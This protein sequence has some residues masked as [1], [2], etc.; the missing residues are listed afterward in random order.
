[1]RAA[2]ATL[3]AAGALTAWQYRDRLSELFRGHAGN[4]PVKKA[5]ILI[6]E[7]DSPAG[8]PDIAVATRDLVAAALD[9]S[10]IVAPVPRGELRVALQMAGRADT[11]RVDAALAQ[12]LAYRSAIRTVVEGRVGRL[13]DGYT[14]VVRLVDAERDSVVLSLSEVASNARALIPAVERA[15]RRIREGL[16]EHRSDIQASRQLF[17]AMTPSFEAYRHYQS[18]VTQVMG[19]DNLGGLAS[20]RAALSLDPDFASTLRLM[21]AAFSNIGEVDSALAA[22]RNALSHPRRLSS[23]QRLLCEAQLA[24]AQG[25]VS[26]A[27]ANYERL[28]EQ[29]PTYMVG[30]IVR[31]YFLY[32]AGRYEEAL[33]SLRVAAEASPFGPSQI[34]LLN[35]FITYLAVGRMEEARQV[36]GNLKGEFGQS[37]P[38]WIGAASGNWALTES[39]G[40][41]LKASPTSSPEMRRLGALAVAAGAASRG[42]VGSAERALRR[43]EGW[44][45]A[46]STPAARVSRQAGQRARLLLALVSGGVAGAPVGGGIQETTTSALVTRGL[47]AAAA[48]DTTHARRLLTAARSRPPGEF[49]REGAGPALL[50][51]LIAAR[52]GFWDETV[53]ILEPA[54]RQGSEIGLFE[55]AGGRV[56]LRWV[57]A[58]AYER[59]GRPDS[60]AAYLEMLG[61]PALVWVKVRA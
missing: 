56:T 43:A 38:V 45:G 60:A 35:Q 6:A 61:L 13:G 51:A 18:A 25:N 31:G 11:T 29:D 14:I 33:G 5:W 44:V 2:V 37:A 49:R 40:T 52:G 17:E 23:R 59:L 30:H 36:A 50:G 12:E 9:E 46:T 48:G 27:V 26:L 10:R 3:L 1:V 34:L 16:G 21:G 53:R 55:D 28:L 47:W 15:A 54:A 4:Q 42:A 22:F 57:V 24:D 8:D 19:G 58:H 39:L 41:A 32:R 20:C 7:F